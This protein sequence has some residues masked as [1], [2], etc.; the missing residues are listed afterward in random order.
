M[1]NIEKLEADVTLAKVLDKNVIVNTSKTKRNTIRAYAANKQPNKGL[2]DEF[3]DI[4]SNG[5]TESLTKPIGIYRGNLAVAIYVKTQ[6]DNT[7]KTQR[8]RQILEQCEAI[9][10]CK[11]YDGFYFEFDPANVITPTTTNLTTG[12]STTII[13]VKWRTSTP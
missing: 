2:D 5:I 6:T 7:A 10:N 11:A 13:N 3:I 8:I 1:S 4:Y 12:Y 9:V